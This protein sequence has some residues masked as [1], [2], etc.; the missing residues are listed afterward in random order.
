MKTEKNSE[1]LQLL[2]EIAK[3]LKKIASAID[4]YGCDGA[5]PHARPTIRVKEDK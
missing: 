3:Y 4:D 1:E 2:R 5:I